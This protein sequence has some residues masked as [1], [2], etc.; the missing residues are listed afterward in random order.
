MSAAL[1]AVSVDCANAGKLADFWSQV[2]GRAVDPEASEAFAAIGLTGGDGACPAWMFHQVPEPKPGKNRV[3]VDL[4]APDL[5]GE[6]DRLL[7][8]GATRLADVEEG[9]YRWTTLADPEGNEFDVVAMP[10]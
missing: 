1:I 5:E 2:T 3:H 10:A 7:T 8:L 4:G 9:G 6:V